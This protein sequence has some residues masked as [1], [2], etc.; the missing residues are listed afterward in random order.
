[1]K[2]H[3]TLLLF[4]G[5][6]LIAGEVNFSKEFTHSS[7][8]FQLMQIHISCTLVGPHIQLQ[9]LGIIS[10]AVQVRRQTWRSSGTRPRVHY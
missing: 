1:M 8:R 2:T 10:P 4:H 7:D 9:V 3:M 5:V 6:G